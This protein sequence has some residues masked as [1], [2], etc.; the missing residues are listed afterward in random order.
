MIVLIALMGDFVMC[1]THWHTVILTTWFK[2]NIYMSVLILLYLSA[3][4][5][6]ESQDLHFHS[7]WL[8][9]WMLCSDFVL[10]IHT[11]LTEPGKLEEVQFHHL[12]S[13]LLDSLG[14]LGLG[15]WTKEKKNACLPIKSN[16]LLVFISYRYIFA[17]MF[18]LC[19]KYYQ[20]IIEHNFILHHMWPQL[21]E[22]SRVICTL[23]QGWDFV[24]LF[25]WDQQRKLMD[26][27]GKGMQGLC[28]KRETFLSVYF[29]DIH[30]IPVFFCS[31]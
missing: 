19:V 18:P 21:Q 4:C 6:C 9:D 28:S 24:H 1:G 10:I 26:I 12:T 13:S 16:P 3:A 23:F 29:K 8:G 7:C 30:L 25:V 27:K 20:T 17:I 22:V 31:L 11:G 14:L 2:S 15:M 5:H